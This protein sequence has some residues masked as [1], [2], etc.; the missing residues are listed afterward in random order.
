MSL[1]SLDLTNL[2]AQVD[3]QLVKHPDGA[4]LRFSEGD[5]PEVHQMG[6]NGEHPLDLL[7][8]TTV[9]TNWAGIGLHCKGRGYDLPDDQPATPADRCT[10]F[11]SLALDALPVSV[12]ILINR[13]GDGRGILRSGR[14]TRL[15]AGAPEGAVG[16]ACRRALGLATAPPPTDTTGL[17][18][19]IW[20]DRVVD[21]A[22]RN[23]RAAPPGWKAV[24]RQHPQRVRGAP[25][26]EAVADATLELADTWPWHR[27]R[28]DPDLVDTAR[29]PL[30]R[31]VTLWMDDGMYARWL[32]AEIPDLRY[33]TDCL[34]QRLAPETVE[35]IAT[36]FALCGADLPTEV[37][38]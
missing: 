9:S 4:I 5:P 21:A 7:L 8:G 19:R 10:S 25:T 32:L 17:W 38:R 20:L 11:A 18:L 35:K 14:A 26:P 1:S 22:A 33:L 37:S 36:T 30:E 24:A 3:A 16:D 28:R 2:V 31:Q 6:L 29:P 12:T 27:L 13:N 15:L 23:A 34:A